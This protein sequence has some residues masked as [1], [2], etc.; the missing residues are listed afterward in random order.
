MLHRKVYIYYKPVI[1]KQYIFI[2]A[3]QNRIEYSSKARLM[4][5]NPD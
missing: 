4:L 2:N 1:I 5:N 3:Y